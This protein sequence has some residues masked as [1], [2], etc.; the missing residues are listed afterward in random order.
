MTSIVPT[1]TP[2]LF[3][4]LRQRVEHTLL[5]LINKN[6]H[7]RYVRESPVFCDFRTALDA[8]DESLLETFRATIP[9]TGYDSYEPFINKLVVQ[10]SNE[11]DVKD[12]FSPG[13]PNFI[14]GSSATSGK[15]PKLFAKYRHTA[16]SSTQDV[17]EQ[18]NPV[19]A[20]GGKNCIVYS[21]TYR[22]VIEVIGEDK[23][24]VS[25]FPIT[26]M[27]SGVIRMQ[28]GV[29]VDKDPFF[30]TLTAPRATSPVAV[31]FIVNYR[32]FLLMHILFALADPQLETVN[33]LF[34]YVFVDMIRHMEEEWDAL[35]HAIET[36]ALPDWEGTSHVRQYLEPK[37]S[38]RPERAAHLRAVGK[39]TEQPG[40]LK[41]LWP[42]L[43]VVIGIASGVFSVIIPKMQHYLG[44]DV[45]MRSLGFTASE[46]YIG[47]A[48][49]ATDL[50]LFKTTSDDIIEFLDMSGLE[51]ASSLVFAHEVK[52]GHR[53]EVVVTT[54]DGL[55]RYRLG[56]VI[57]IAGF[58]ST[59]GSPILRYIERRGTSVRVQ[60]VLVGE[61][62]LTS[63]IFSAQDVLGSI[64][65]MTVIVD[66]RKV[67]SSLAYLV[68]I[69]GELSPS[70][71]QAPARIEAALGGSN[72]ILMKAFA[73]GKLAPPTVHVLKTG[74][75]REYRALKI[76]AAITGTGQIKVPVV[77]WD[78]E[79]QEWMLQ[80]VE[81]VIARHDE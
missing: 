74:T 21:L 35:V 50:S 78:Q 15:K 2:E 11:N 29:D 55:W 62:E 44:P 65:E 76:K 48:C 79:V 6:R 73:K 43:D 49:S 52:L 41:K 75:F 13:L 67:P 42:G 60:G 10:K 24:T 56:D 45:H 32:S 70:A 68:E 4:S 14:A 12:M 53:Y 17:D 64:T 72:D 61:E 66:D 25:R 9:L 39:A 8:N 37:F 5:H 27:S 80:R 71:D 34:G 23:T 30:I 57:E 54:R 58:D 33:T 81:K 16:R 26:S 63:A 59:D 38:A 40:W 69:D 7:T 3:D 18:A 28:H 51:T 36:G 22:E 46:A 1:L 47:T 19:S 20:E 31:S 77:L